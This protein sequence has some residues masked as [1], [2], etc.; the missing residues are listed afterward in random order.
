MR[1]FRFRIEKHLLLGI[2][3]LTEEIS[4][5]FEKPWI[6]QTALRV[7]TKQWLLKY[8]LIMIQKAGIVS[9]YFSRKLCHN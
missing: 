7:E 2:C 9:A 3:D 4:A 8:V 6:I 5:R 1:L